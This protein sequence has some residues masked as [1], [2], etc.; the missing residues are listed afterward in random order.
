[1]SFP[2]YPK[3]L[4]Q[5][6]ILTPQ[7]HFAAEKA[8]YEDFS[9][10]ETI[11][12]CFESSLIEHFKTRADVQ[13]AKFWTGEIVYFSETA[14]KV[15]LVGNFGIGGPAASHIMEILIATGVTKFIIV[16]HAG[17]LQPNH[18]AGTIVL[19]EKSIR[20]EGLSHHYL[21]PS[22]FAYA[23]S[24]TMERLVSQLNKAQVKY[25]LGTSWTIDS[26]YR[27]TKDEVAQYA[28]EGV[29]AVEMEVASLFSVGTF[30]KVQ[31]GALLVISDYVGPE[32]WEAHLHADETSNAL[33][34]ATEVAMATSI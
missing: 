11:I 10:P 21:I 29:V 17:G 5:E 23:S 3:R 18:P 12:L 19:C 20:D 22:K 32:K 4:A 6:V 2:Q 25:I 9:A 24:H 14:K 33:I 26:M 30:R 28:K 31:V 1:M 34:R 16:G 8:G 13:H 7:D 27:E 15:G